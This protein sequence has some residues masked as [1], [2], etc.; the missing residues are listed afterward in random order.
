[1][2]SGI[3]ILI[4]NEY[5]CINYCTQHP[6][7]LGP[8]KTT[9]I[10]WIRLFLQ[11]NNFL[12]PIDIVNFYIPPINCGNGENRDQLFDATT[13]FSQA[14][15]DYDTFHSL[16]LLVTGDV[17]AHA[18]EWDSTTT[19]DQLEYEIMGF[20]DYNGL[21]V[22]NGSLPTYHSLYHDINKD[23]SSHE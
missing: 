1:V 18:V 21:V 4:Y 6:L 13:I 5:S 11:H 2:K 16:S 3:M 20:L 10:V 15:Q 12:L 19:E 22:L 8:N 14:F 17:N 9:K 7:D 23:C